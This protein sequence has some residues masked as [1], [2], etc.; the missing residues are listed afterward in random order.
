MITISKSY[1]FD[2]AHKLHNKDWSDNENEEEFGKCS[3]LHGHTYQVTVT[4]TGPVSQ[5]TGMVLNYFDLDYIMKPLVGMW[6]HKYL[7]DVFHTDLTTAENMVWRMAEAI[8]GALVQYHG[9]LYHLWEVKLQ[10]T[11]KTSA[12]WTNYNYEII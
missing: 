9:P 8:Q 7:N 10:E 4:V 11:P 1:S 3:R 2:S 5:S 12:V 6:D